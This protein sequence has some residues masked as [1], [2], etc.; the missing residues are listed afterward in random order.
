MGNG[1]CGGSNS[2]SVI[3]Q[4]KQDL[5]GQLPGGNGNMNTQVD[6]LNAS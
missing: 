4:A 1:C 3:M 2:A 5:D 6:I